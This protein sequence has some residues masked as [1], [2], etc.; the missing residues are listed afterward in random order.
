M[1]KPQT[2]GELV[3]IGLSDEGLSL[4]CLSRDKANSLSIKHNAFH[5]CQ[6]IDDMQRQLQR[7]V[8]EFK[9]HQHPVNFALGHNQFSF[10]LTEAPEVEDAELQKAMRWKARELIDAELDEVVIDSFP[11]VGQKQRGRQPMAY[12]VAA[13]VDVLRSYVDLVEHSD[14][15]LRSIDIPALAQRNLAHQLAEDKNGVALLG[16]N[17]QSSLLTLTRQGELYL[18][19]DIEVG[20]ANFAGESAPGDGELQIE[21]LPPATQNTLDTI[22]LEVQRSVDYYERYFA[23]P[24]IQSLVIAPMPVSV[25]GMVEYMAS[26]LGMQVR[27]MDLNVLFDLPQKIARDAQSLCLPAIGAALRWPVAE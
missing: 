12:L 8:G 17:K 16:L 5:P 20:Y 27:E 24:Q 11:I 10:L 22:V 1:K 18:A 3:G 2:A 19:R 26:Q 23:Q 4:A 25:N 15:Q 21:G 9:L 14:L 6:S 7:W 13:S